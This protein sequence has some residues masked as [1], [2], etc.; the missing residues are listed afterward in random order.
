MKGNTPD[1]GSPDPE[2]HNSPIVQAM[3]EDRVDTLDDALA[4]SVCYFNDKAYP[5]GTHVRSGA[6]VLRCVDGVWEEVGP[7]DPDNP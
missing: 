2:R 5:A 4:G 3:D 6:V 1:V 7:A